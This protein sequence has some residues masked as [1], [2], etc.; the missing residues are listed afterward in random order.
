MKKLLYLMLILSFCPLALADD[1]TKAAPSPGS[2]KV[3]APNTALI[4]FFK[5]LQSGQKQTVVTYGTSVTKYGYWVTAMQQWFDQKYPG[6]VTVVNSGGPGQ[7]SD[8]GLKELQPQ[9]LDHYPDL[10]FIEFAAN[11]A[12]VRFKLT[13]EHAKDNLDK[14]VTAI[15]Q[16]NPQ[17]AIV[18]QTMNV[19][20]DAPKGFTT[21]ATSRPQLNAFY[22]N[23]RNYATEHKLVLVDNYVKWEE[24]KEK[25]YANFQVML[26]DGT[27]PNKNGS[28]AVNW[29]NIQA[30]LEAAQ[31]AAT[32]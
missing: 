13:V 8:W 21:A 11:D 4:A 12:H 2:T 24:M 18:L 10:V 28:L 29:P 25:D 7:N 30:L 15:Q 5:H 9:V 6:L 19:F 1:A 20:W 27:H 31:K 22:D 23:Y 17:V 16:Q 32:P 14:I 26:P 3:T